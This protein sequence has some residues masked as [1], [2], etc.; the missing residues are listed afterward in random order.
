MTRS[1]N[2][3]PSVC[4]IAHEALVP[5]L[6]PDRVEEDERI[7]DVERAVLPFAYFLQHRIGHRRD[8]V[9]RHVDAVELLKV[10]AYL[11]HRHAARINGD[12]LGVEIGKAALVFGDQLRVECAG[13]VA[14]DRKLHLRRARQHRLLRMPVAPVGRR[15]RLPFIVEVLVQLRVQDALRKRRL[16]IVEQTVPRKHLVR[17]AA[18]QQPG[19]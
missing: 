4:F 14:R 19:Q 18:G 11:A 6:D 17:V 3:A 12:D 13:P 10:A 5:D 15:V 7:A 8:Q 9:G 16:Q 1:Q 2:L